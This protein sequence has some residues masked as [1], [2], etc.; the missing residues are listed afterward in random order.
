[1]RMRPRTVASLLMLSIVAAPAAAADDLRTVAERSGYTATATYDETVDLCRRLDDRSELV[2]LDS[3]GTTAEGRSIPLL[4]VSDPPVAS[5]EE[6]RASGKLVVLAIGSIHG[7]EVCGKEALPM[8]VRE[9][10]DRPDHPLLD[11]IILCVAPLFNADGAERIAP[12]NRPG[13]LGPEDGMGERQNAQGLDLNRD[14]VALSAPETRGLVRFLDAWDPH[15]FLDTHTTNGSAH[16]YLITYDGPKNPATHPEVLAFSR[17]QFLPAVA[18]GFHQATG[19]HAFSYGNFE[20]D[21]S[22]WTTYP[23]HPRFGTTYAGLRNRLSLLSEAYAYASFEDRVNGTRAFVRSALDVAASRK[24]E[25]CSLLDRARSETIAADGAEV[26]IRSE[27]RPFDVPVT[28]LGFEET[29]GATPSESVAVGV[30]KDYTVSLVHRF[31]PTLAVA[32]PFAYVIPPGH[33]GAVD[34]LRR[35]GIALE[36][37]REDVQVDAEIYRL[38]EVRRRRGGYVGPASVEAEAS[39]RQ[40]SYRVEAGSVLVRTSQPMGTL[41]TYLLEPGSD[42]NLMTHGL[43][44]DGIEAGDDFPAVRLVEQVALLTRP[45]PPIDEDED[46]GEKEPITFDLLDGRDAPDFGGRPSSVRWLDD[47]H[48]LQT[49]DGRPMKVEAATGEAEPYLDPEPIAEALATL[50]TIGPED[51][52]RLARRAIAGPDPTDSGA[53]VE[54]GEDLYYVALDGSKALRLTS[55]PGEEELP[56]FSPDGRFVAFVR[57]NDLYVVDVETATERALTTGGTDLVRNGKAVWVYFEELF[58]RSWKAFWWSP[59]GEHLAFLRLDDRP[60]DAHTVLDDTGPR[61][62]VEETPYP[63]AGDPNPK[64]A[65]AVVPSAGGEP[66]F[67]DLSNYLDGSFLISHVG[68]LPDGG[69]ALCYVQDRTQTWLDVLRVPTSGG[70]PETLFRETTEAWVESPGAPTFL[71][72]GS[73]LWP[74]ERDGWKHLYHYSADGELLKQLTMGEWEVRSVEHLD[75]EGRAVYVTGTLDSHVAENLYRVSIDDLC[76]DR[77]TKEDGD[78][79]VSIAPD[80]THFIDT[81]SSVTTPPK[82]ALRS[83]ADGSIV[84]IIDDNPLPDLEKY[85]FG[86]RELV[87]IETPDGFTLEGEL[88]LPPDLDESKR[89]PVWFQTYGGP[90]YPTIRDSWAGARATDQALAQEGFIVFRADPRSA[91]GKGAVSAWSAYKRLGIQELED[92]ETAIDWLKERPYV[93]PDR[94]G[95]TGHSYGGFMTAFALTH[96]DRFACGIAGAPVTDWRNYDSIYTER[97]M[98]TPQENPEGYASTSVVGA[99]GDL[100]GRL[101]IVHGAKDDNVS[102][103]NT[104]QLIHNL[105]QA[106]K[107]FELM[108]YPESRHG[109]SS[110]HYADLRLDFIRRT[111]GGGPRDRSS[112]EEAEP[113][114][115]AGSG[116]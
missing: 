37:V 56:E 80:G 22:E 102:L 88:I 4:I 26:A 76:V 62:A 2:R 110:D 20:D 91:S 11:D 64:V 45:I 115:A 16:R 111:L 67:A 33:D 77:L 79:S 52:D 8:L 15:L 40:E 113:A 57:A 63:F 66:R 28:I 13:Q 9:L 7:G 30:P 100:H 38:D 29:T 18:D 27:A 31:E 69:A 50:P 108:V 36:H 107:P 81:W 25:I 71:P 59:D 114:A 103:R 54:H 34:T 89:Y 58:G 96:S 43:L 104:Y 17:Y 68:W 82:V 74:S 109:I 78:H 46:S 86:P 84:R 23:A 70:P 101:L 41:A 49:R 83:T 32:R 61:R 14:F 44:A 94:I 93:D 35:H 87:R 95:M 24:E 105:Q 3:L 73:F 5:A 97:Y 92:I 19:E 85:T 106:G 99:A 116:R 72:D 65:M 39:A 47:G 55:A 112:A 6:A 60:L 42:D 1:M 10:T 12:D 21:H 51:A 53:L 90:H 75:P 98:L 48:F